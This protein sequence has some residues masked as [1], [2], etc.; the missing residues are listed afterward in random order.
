MVYRI[1]FSQCRNHADADDLTQ[2]V[3]VQ[4]IHKKPELFSEEHLKA[5]LIRVTINASKSLLRS[6]W[7]RKIVPLSEYEHLPADEKTQSATLCAVLSLPEKYRLVILLYYFEDYSV[8]EIAGILG[9]TKTAIQTQLY[10]ARAML[11]ELLKEDWGN[12]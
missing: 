6:A 1:A 9:R 12:D 5:W 11:K 2:E 8:N 7:R 10:R 3:F 4:Y